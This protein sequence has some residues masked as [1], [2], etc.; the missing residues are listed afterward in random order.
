MYNTSR[1]VQGSSMTLLLYIFV[2]SAIDFVFCR[3]ELK[4]T[5]TTEKD[6]VLE[7]KY[8]NSLENLNLSTKQLLGKNDVAFVNCDIPENFKISELFGTSVRRLSISNSTTL[9]KYILLG[10]DNLVHLSL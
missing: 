10:L 5:N 7:C 1:T 4:I 3:E 8:G 6:I 9:K 2:L